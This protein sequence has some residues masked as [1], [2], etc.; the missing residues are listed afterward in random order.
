MLN[1]HHK[2]WIVVA[3]IFFTVAVPIIINESY[4]FGSQTGVFCLTEWK[5]AD[6]LTYYGSV[7]GGGATVLAL[8]YTIVFTRMQ[9]RRE[10][11]LE[12][13]YATWKKI[14]TIIS[15]VLLDILPLKMRNTSKLDGSLNQN[16][17]T[18]ISHLQTYALTAKTS[19]DIVKCYVSPDEYDKIG[20]YISELWHAIEQFCAIENELEQ[21]YTDL[22]QSA[23]QNGGNIP[24]ELLSSSLTAANQLFKT[25]IP[26]AYNGL[27]Q[28]LLNMKRDVF[29]KIYA[30]ID[31][32][33]DKMLFFSKE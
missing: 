21:I 1:R 26:D 5:A 28:D 6:M 8:V 17:H 24:D 25:K 19:L 20:L 29:R 32:Q 33:A 15:Q 22:Q 27:Y 2:F 16:I 12:S 10:R 13:S 23:L 18:I 9:L 3:A 7:L 14:D 31:D 11:F 30:E 4:K